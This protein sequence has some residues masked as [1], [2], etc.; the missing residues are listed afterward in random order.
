MDTCLLLQL[1]L[2]NTLVSGSIEERSIAPFLEQLDSNSTIVFTQENVVNIDDFTL[3]LDGFSATGSL[4]VAANPQ[5]RTYSFHFK[6]SETQLY[7]PNY[8]FGNVY[9]EIDSK[10]P[11]VDPTVPAFKKQVLMIPLSDSERMRVCLSKINGLVK[12]ELYI[13][14]GA[15]NQH[16]RR[17]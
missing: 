5:K 3:E 17:L 7:R 9:Q 1:L 14:Q 15:L 6:T 2:A 8:Y 13:R 12:L 16:L 10:L 4:L 11:Q